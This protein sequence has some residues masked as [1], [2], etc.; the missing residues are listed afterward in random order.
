[1]HD[2]A[3]AVAEGDFDRRM[4]PKCHASKMHDVASAVAEGDFDR[5]MFPKCHASKMHDAASLIC[6]A[7]FAWA[8]F[9]SEPYKEN[10]YERILSLS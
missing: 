2:I 7:D 6:K 5:R 1:M 10:L 4:F 3:S 9:L 8:R